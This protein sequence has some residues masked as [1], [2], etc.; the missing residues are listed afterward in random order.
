MRPPSP[1]HMTEQVTVARANTAEGH[2]S[3]TLPSTN[4]GVAFCPSVG[5]CAKAVYL[6]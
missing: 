6:L 4:G 1:S 5:S 3:S 2:L